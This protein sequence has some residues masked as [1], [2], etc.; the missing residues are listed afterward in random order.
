MNDNHYKTKCRSTARKN[1]GGEG[2]K[3]GFECLFKRLEDG[4]NICRHTLRSFNQNI[5]S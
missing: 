5:E 4:G 3:G 2:S 1:D